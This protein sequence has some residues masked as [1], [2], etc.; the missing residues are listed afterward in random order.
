M[1]GNSEGAAVVLGFH[2]LRSVH[3]ASG[4]D[5]FQQRSRGTEHTCLAARTHPQWSDRGS[6]SVK[7]AFVNGASRYV[8]AGR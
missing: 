1:T 7:A 8:F 3:S 6:P 2:R 5:P 4:A